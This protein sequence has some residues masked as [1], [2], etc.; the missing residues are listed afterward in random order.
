M[1]K[2]VTSDYSRATTINIRVSKA[3][4]ALIKRQAEKHGMTVSAYLVGLA[5]GWKN[6]LGFKDK[7]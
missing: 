2:R 3:E 5:L 7:V 6:Q 1:K 4:K